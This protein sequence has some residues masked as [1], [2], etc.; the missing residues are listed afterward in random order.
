LTCLTTLLLVFLVLAGEMGSAPASNGPMK[1][2]TLAQVGID[3]H[4]G[5]GKLRVAPAEGSA[6]LDR[7]GAPGAAESRYMDSTDPAAVRRLGC[8][9]GSR[10]AR[11]P[12]LRDSVVVLD[13]GRPMRRHH[14]FGTSIF[15]R[16]FRTTDAIRIAS[17]AYVQW[18]WDC[19]GSHHAVRLVLAIGTNNYGRQVT[20]SHGAAWAQ[21]VNA[22]ADWAAE[23]GFGWHVT[24]AGAADIELAWNGP[25]PSRR[26][27][28][29]YASVAQHPYFDYGDAAGCPPVGDC[30]GSWTQEDVWYVAWGAKFA[31]PLPEIY[32]PTG[33]QASEWQRLSLYAR[34]RHGRA[35]T[36]AGAMSQ[37]AACRQAKDPCPGM[38][39]SPGRAWRLLSRALNSDPRT[40]QPLRWLTD[41]RWDH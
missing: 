26:W 40:R 37:R 23:Q 8:R 34:L 32:N 29:G 21:M 11:D 35:M 15:W 41:V 4:D 1:D 2:I 9:F 10:V 12:S 5:Q 20:P 28:Q 36:I 14:V 19:V 7:R 16:R 3:P 22:A 17:Q 30:L 38:N 18:Y 25:A 6:V 31:V 24:M 39:N 13:F 33:S 27:V